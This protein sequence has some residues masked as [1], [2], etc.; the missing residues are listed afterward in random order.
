MRFFFIV[1]FAVALFFMTGCTQKE[2]EKKSPPFKATAYTS[3]AR[4]KATMR[5][6]TVLGKT[7]RPTYVKVG[8]KMRGISSWY[9][10][11]FHGK[12][13]SN[14]ERYNMYAK[15]AAHKTWPMDT[16]VKVTNLENGKSTVVRINDRGPFVKG[17]IIDC[18]YAAGKEIGLDK[19]GIAKVE[20]EVVGF[21][22][23]IAKKSSGKHLVKS[24]KKDTSKK[25][26]LNNFGIQL[27]A[28]RNK[29][30]AYHARRRYAKDYNRG[31]LHVTVRQFTKADGTPIFRVWLMGFKT[32]EEAK[33]FRKCRGLIGPIVRN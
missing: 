25:V 12:Y 21:A 19:S 33:A 13:T 4:H 9:G 16:M 31:D 28:F 15:T 10:P 5:C 3:A 8:Q 11:N 26:L 18:S 30:R 29:T 14:G 22:G 7:Y 24:E 27:A 2:P 1:G 32:E 17:R 23:K 20:I 6:Y